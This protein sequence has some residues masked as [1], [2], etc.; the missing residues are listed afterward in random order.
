[1]TKKSDRK[2]KTTTKLV[3]QTEEQ[4]ELVVLKSKELRTNKNG[5]DML[6]IM[7]YRLTQITTMAMTVNRGGESQQKLQNCEY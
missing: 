7:K 2:C 3:I 1:M 4:R 6:D 5:V